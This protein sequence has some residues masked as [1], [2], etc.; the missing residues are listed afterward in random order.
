VNKSASHFGRSVSGT[1]NAPIVH[2]HGSDRVVD[3]RTVVDE[4]ACRVLAAPEKKSAKLRW[5]LRLYVLARQEIAR[6]CKELKT[7]AEDLTLHSPGANRIFV[8]HP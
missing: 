4:V 5:L 6:R 8:H 1:G 7:Q 3:A 2:P